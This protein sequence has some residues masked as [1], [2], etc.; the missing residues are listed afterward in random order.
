[1]AQMSYEDFINRVIQQESGGNPRAV[2]PAGAIGLMQLMPAT[3]RQVAGELG[4]NDIAAMDEEE[5]RNALFDPNLNRQFGE[6]YMKGRIKKYGGD[7]AAAAVGYNGGDSR[8]DA[9]LKSGRND[10]VIPKETSGYYR[11]ILGGGGSDSLA[12]G[13]GSDGFAGYTGLLSGGGAQPQSGGADPFPQASG[14]EKWA[15]WLMGLG[16]AF[17]GNADP[18]YLTAVSELENKGVNENKTYKA[19]IS[20]GIDPATAEWA[21]RDPRVMQQLAQQLFAPK[22]KNMTI[23][24]IFD[25][26]TGRPVKVLVDQTTGEYQPLGGVQAPDQTKAPQLQPIEIFDEATGRKRKAIFNPTTGQMEPLGGIEAADAGKAATLQ[27]VEV[28]DE[29]TGGKRKVQFN[30]Q[31]GEITPIGGVEAAGGAVTPYQNERLNLDRERLKLQQQNAAARTASGKL[32]AAVATKNKEIEIAATNL[33]QALADYEALVV[34]GERRDGTT[35][36]GTGYAFTGTERDA[37]NTAR[38]NIQMQMKELF[39]LG[40]I[41]GPDMQILNDMLVDPTASAGPINSFNPISDERGMFSVLAN[42]A[43]HYAGLGTG[44][45]DRV[46]ANTKQLREQFR[47]MVMNRGGAVPAAGTPPP[48]GGRPDPAPAAGLKSKYGLE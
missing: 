9:W 26:A 39:T 22:S 47:Q 35:A 30:P 24:E 25:P 23:S 7:Y 43:G 2:S 21:V 5:L 19:L 12:G 3:A 37:V 10:A 42:T 4:R 48:A 14:R 6:H 44:M 41:T 28:Y 38:R 18:R 33:D 40:A 20:R 36:P 1:M 31:T 17:R 11:S 34:G 13:G 45:A 29:K 32:P 46:K 15:T 16:Q 27:V 8:A